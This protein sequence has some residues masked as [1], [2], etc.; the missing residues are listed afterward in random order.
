MT[1][2]TRSTS[3]IISNEIVINEMTS[4]TYKIDFEGNR[5]VEKIDGFEALKQAIYCILN[6][7]RYEHIIYSH[8]YGSELNNA[9]GLDYDLAKSEVERYVKEAILA[10]DRFTEI[11]NYTTSKISSDSM[12]I[13]FDVLTKYGSTLNVEKEVGV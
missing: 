10:D 12:M 8:N 2:Q 13:S 4:K 7:I 9:I 11:Q 1:P 5:I 6:T 3:Q